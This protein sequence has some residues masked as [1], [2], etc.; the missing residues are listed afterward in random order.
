[1]IAFTVASSMPLFQVEV[2]QVA[3]VVDH[4]F[5]VEVKQVAGS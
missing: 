2:K 5:Q 3:G 1:V 4:S